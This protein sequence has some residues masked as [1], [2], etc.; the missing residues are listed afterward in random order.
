MEMIMGRAMDRIRGNTGFSFINVS[1]IAILQSFCLIFCRTKK[2]R[3]IIE[4]DDC[5][6]KKAVK[7]KNPHEILA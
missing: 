7:L 3:T 6:A 4:S 5:V 1:F 2:R